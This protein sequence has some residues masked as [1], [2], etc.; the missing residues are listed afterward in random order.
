MTPAAQGTVE[1]QQAR[2]GC[3]TASKFGVVMGQPK[4]KGAV[5]TNA[6]KTYACELAAE[7][8]TGI[9]VGGGGSAAT[10][11]G[12]HH[13]DQARAAYELT[14]LVGCKPSGFVNRTKTIGG[15][16]DGF[17]QSGDR[18]WIHEI[19]SP[20]TSRVQVETWL[21][22]MPSE[23]KPQVQ[24]NLWVTERDRCDFVSYDPRMPDKLRLYVEEVARDDDYIKK[25]ASRV[26]EFDRYVQTIVEK[27]T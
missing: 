26:T 17:T 13:E 2:C 9:A 3:V 1:W 11:W 7:R 21:Y 15:S 12:H 6:A 24:G 27:L 16:P 10:E 25:L 14:E 19:K 4:T 20:F 8:I 5:W 18:V 23:H 22:G